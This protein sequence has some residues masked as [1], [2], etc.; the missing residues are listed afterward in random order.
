MTRVEPRWPIQVVLG[1]GLAAL[2][3][4]AISARPACRWPSL[5]VLGAAGLCGPLARRRGT[6]SGRLA[7]FVYAPR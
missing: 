4:P 1:G 3:V 5:V 2:D 6:G 7:G